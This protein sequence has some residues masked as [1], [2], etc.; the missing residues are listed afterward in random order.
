[1][2]GGW[3]READA[4]AAALAILR[5]DPAA[6]RLDEAPGDGESEAGTAG[7]PRLVSAPEPLE[8]PL[9]GLGAETDAGVLDRDSY[10]ALVRLDPNRDRAVARRVA[11]GVRPEVHEHP[12]DLLRC[13]PRRH[14]VRDVRREPP[15]TAARPPPPP[16]PPSS[17]PPPP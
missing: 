12:L 3:K 11:E 8:H 15:A 13:E 6:V 14:V 16:L 9:A 17:T 10:L 7:R 2:L 1:M 5:P 4:G